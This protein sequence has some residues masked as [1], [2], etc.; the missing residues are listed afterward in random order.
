MT[1]PDL[2]AESA[3]LAESR[4][5]DFRARFRVHYAPVDCFQLIRNLSLFPGMNLFSQ[6]VNNASSAFDAKAIWLPTIDTYLIQYREPPERWKQRS[7]SRR[8]NFSMAHELGHIFCGHLKL[9]EE[10]KND[11]TLRMEDL[12]A[13]A[14]AGRLLM[15]DDALKQFCSVQEAADAL[16]VSESAIRFR[17]RETGIV[18]KKRTCPW[19][20]FDKIPPGALYCR[21][22]RLKLADDPEKA[23]E[24]TMRW[25]VPEV[26]PICESREPAA[27]ETCPDCRYAR[28]NRCPDGH[29]APNGAWYCEVCGKETE[30]RRIKRTGR[31]EF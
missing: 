17:L 24:I 29:A 31:L 25:P 20:G 4:L 10:M 28:R 30:V 6:P 21:M 2:A 1:N 12:E 9:P 11:E 13:D 16:W 7:G 22:C 23:P 14:F 19:C 26:C 5:R 27:G 8:C 15:P 3:R 18:L